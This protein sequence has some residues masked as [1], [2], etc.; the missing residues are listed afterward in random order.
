MNNRVLRVLALLAVLS[1]AV[2]AGAIA[3]GGIVYALT[4]TRGV[5]P[6]A[7]AQAADPGD[8]I[9]IASVE[10]DSPAAEAG[11]VR[12]DI[13]LAI[14]DQI[15]EDRGDLL[16]CLDELEPGDE[17]ELKVLHGDDQRTLTATLG[18]R[19]IEPTW[20]WFRAMACPEWSRSML[21]RAARSSSR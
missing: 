16:R 18:E 7:R 9:V 12:S 13:L 14:D 8:G 20:G 11:A 19:T 10:P 15:L 4:Q 1:L 6:V 5:V 21:M 2:A 17:V 3:G